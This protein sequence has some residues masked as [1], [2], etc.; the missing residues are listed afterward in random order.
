[1]SDLRDGTKKWGAEPI[2]SSRLSEDA[3][4]M[5]AFSSRGPTADGR[6]KPEVVA[7]GTNIVSAR[8]THEKATVGWGTY[9]DK[10]LY[11][12]GTSMATPLS[13]GALGIL[14]QFL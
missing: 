4:G 8:S 7:P 12:G 3:R 6:I 14:R 2:A 1:M 11:M 9:G 13:S 5:A 10:Y